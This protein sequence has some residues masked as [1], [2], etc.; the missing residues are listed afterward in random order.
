MYIFLWFVVVLEGLR[1]LWIGCKGCGSMD[2][3][4]IGKRR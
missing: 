1:F 3:R 2:F 4:R